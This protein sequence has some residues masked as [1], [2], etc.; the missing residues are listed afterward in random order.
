MHGV[1]TGNGP[2][3]RRAP[4]TRK[5]NHA[6]T[7]A[8]VR[9]VLEHRQLGLAAAGYWRSFRIG[10]GWPVA[11][12]YQVPL[13][14]LSKDEAIGSM[15]AWVSPTRVRDEIPALCARDGR[16]PMDGQ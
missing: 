16:P 1:H 9:V 6:P 14:Q 7:F 4:S 8:I 12:A 2:S 5:H 3:Q 15:G 10:S 13:G 11:P